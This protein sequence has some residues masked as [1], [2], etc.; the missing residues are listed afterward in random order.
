[1]FDFETGAVDCAMARELFRNQ[2]DVTVIDKNEDVGG[3][4]SKSIK[5]Y[6]TRS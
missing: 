5:I 2:L 6:Y 4:A 1:M 3:D